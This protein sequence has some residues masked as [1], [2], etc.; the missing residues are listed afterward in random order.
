[1][2]KRALLL[3]IIMFITALV[4]W[5]AGAAQNREFV[6][7]TP[8]AVQARVVEIIDVNAIRVRTPIGDALVRLIGIHPNGTTEAINY[9]SREIM[10]NNV[11][12][13]RDEL[14]PNVGRWNYMYVIHGDRFINGEL[15][16]TGF[17]HLNANHGQAAQFEQIEA[18]QAIARMAGLGMWAY[19]LRTPII[20]HHRDR[21]NINTATPFQIADRLGVTPI[22]ATNLATFR[23]QS[24]F[25]HIDHVKFVPGT[26]KEFFTLNRFRMVVAT[27]INSASI[28]EI[29]TL[30]GVTEEQAENIVNSR[31]PIPFTNI[32]QL[33]SLGLMSQEQFDANQP[34]ITIETVDTI[35][36]AAPNSRANINLAN[37]MQL[38]LAGASPVQATAIV[39]QR[40]FMPL[41]NLQDLSNMP[42]FGIAQIHALGDNM[43]TFTDINSAPKSEIESLFGDEVLPSV[44]NAIMNHRPFF[45]TSEIA[46]YMS[47][48]MF[49]KIAPF[50]YADI[51]PPGLQINLN[52]ASFEQLVGA[53][54]PRETAERI[55]NSVRRNI[56]RPSQVPDWLGWE[57]RELSSLYTNINTAIRLELLSLDNAMDEDIVN[58]IIDY[59]NEQ[60]FGSRAEIEEFFD[61]L[62]LRDLFFRI[63]NFIVVR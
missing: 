27:N 22:F 23:V 38:A 51:K 40:E 10:G 52:T 25:Q 2:R 3:A 53:G 8:P 48:A 35:H 1:M 19:E 46:Q 58:R 33:V 7:L 15:V 34:F 29:S 59:R 20:N 62:G 13:V 16:L 47:A 41:R 63:D 17:G 50:I 36:F 57:L 30:I 18:G 45:S 42:G 28:E 12:L 31:N 26:T 11:I 4:P 56:L 60:I 55:V 44:V 9:L 21:I 43:R 37:T 54:F 61:Q 39:Q 32:N 14:F 24:V 5:Q 49:D 6:N